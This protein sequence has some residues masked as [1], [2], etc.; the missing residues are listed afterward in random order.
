MLFFIFNVLISI[1]Y[2][3][4]FSKLDSTRV[5]FIKTE[6]PRVTAM[7]LSNYLVVVSSFLF[8]FVGMSLC[9]VLRILSQ[10]PFSGLLIAD[11]GYSVWLSL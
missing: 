6:L 3:G 10:I 2:L 4:T 8:V 9:L 1:C 11:T 7:D 5:I